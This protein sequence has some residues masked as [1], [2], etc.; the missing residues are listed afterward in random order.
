[1]FEVMYPLNVIAF[2]GIVYVMVIKYRRTRDRGFI[3]L[4]L[5]LVI[6]PLVAHC[7]EVGERVLIDRLSE[8]QT[9][10]LYPFSLVSRGR[11]TIGYLKATLI[12]LHRFIENALILVALVKLHRG[13]RTVGLAD[14]RAGKPQP[15]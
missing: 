7:L 2:I 15:A 14:K 10:S 6:W 12:L 8:G 5:A 13:K 9:V 1:M 4:G 11:I 3:W